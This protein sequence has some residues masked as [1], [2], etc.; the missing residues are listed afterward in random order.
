MS[1]VL[2][3]DQRQQ[4][5]SIHPPDVEDRKIL[6]IPDPAQLRRLPL[7][8]RLSLRLGL[9]LLSRG[10]HRRTQSEHR[11]AGENLI[12]LREQAITEHEA[13][14]WLSYDLHRGL[15]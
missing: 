10:L 9:W 2:L 8:D 15:R 4:S 5:T 13:I 14:T 1:T 12:A 3:S 11:S 6:S 7:F